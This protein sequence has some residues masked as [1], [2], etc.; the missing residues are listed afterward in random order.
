MTTTGTKAA[1]PANSNIVAFRNHF[2]NNITWPDK[3]AT[4]YFPPKYNLINPD[5][6]TWYSNC[7]HVE[8]AKR[9]K[10]DNPTTQTFEYLQIVIKSDVDTIQNP[11]G[12]PNVF[13]LWKRLMS[14]VIG[15]ENWV[16][17]GTYYHDTEY[18][19]GRG[20]SGIMHNMGMLYDTVG[21]V[22]TTGNKYRLKTFDNVNLPDAG[23]GGVFYHDFVFAEGFITG[24]GI[25]VGTAMT[26]TSGSETDANHKHRGNGAYF[27]PM[28]SQGIRS[29]EL[30]EEKLYLFWP[31]ELKDWAGNV[32]QSTHYQFHIDV[33]LDPTNV[34][35]VDTNSIMLNMRY[36]LR[37]GS[38]PTGKAGPIAT[39]AYQK[40]NGSVMTAF[41]VFDVFCTSKGTITYRS[42]V[43]DGAE[44]NADGNS[45]VTR[46]LEVP[47]D[48]Y[49]FD[50]SSDSLSSLTFP[51]NSNGIST[52]IECSIFGCQTLSGDVILSLWVPNE[53]NINSSYIYNMYYTIEGGLLVSQRRPR[54]RLANNPF[55]TSLQD[56]VV[57]TSTRAS[58]AVRMAIPFKS[59][60]MSASSCVIPYEAGTLSLMMI[61]LGREKSAKKI[62]LRQLFVDEDQSLLRP[63]SSEPLRNMVTSDQTFDL[64]SMFLETPHRICIGVQKLKAIV[65]GNVNAVTDTGLENL[66]QDHLVSIILTRTKSDNVKNEDSIL[67]LIM[68]TGVSNRGVSFSTREEDE[69]GVDLSITDD[70]V[71]QAIIPY[72]TNGGDQGYSFKDGGLVAIKGATIEVSAIDKNCVSNETGFA[73]AYVQI[74]NTDWDR[75]GGNNVI[76]RRLPPSPYHQP[77]YVPT[78]KDGAVIGLVGDS[79]NNLPAFGKRIVPLQWTISN[80]FQ[81]SVSPALREDT[82]HSA[83]SVLFYARDPLCTQVRVKV[84]TT[85]VQTLIVFEGIRSSQQTLA[86]VE[87]YD[88][89]GFEKLNQLQTYTSKSVLLYMTVDNNDKTETEPFCAFLDHMNTTYLSGLYVGLPA[90]GITQLRL[91]QPEVRAS[92]DPQFPRDSIMYPASLDW[93]ALNKVNDRVAHLTFSDTEAP[94]ITFNRPFTMMC[95]IGGQLFYS[96]S[97]TGAR[98]WTYNND[99]DDWARL[100]L[101]IDKDFQTPTITLNTH[102]FQTE[103]TIPPQLINSQ[104]STRVTALLTMKVPTLWEP[105]TRQIVYFDFPTNIKGS[106]SLTDPASLLSSLVI[107][108]Q[109]GYSVSMITIDEINIQDTAQQVVTVNFIL[110]VTFDGVPIEYGTNLEVTITQINR[111]NRDD[112]VK[113]TYSTAIADGEVSIPYTFN[114]SEYNWT[115]YA[116]SVS[117]ASTRFELNH[118][119]KSTITVTRSPGDQSVATTLLP[120][121]DRW[122]N[123]AV[124]ATETRTIKFLP[125]KSGTKVTGLAYVHNAAA[126]RDMAYSFSVSTTDTTFVDGLNGTNIPQ[127]L[128]ACMTPS[129][130]DQ[131]I[132]SVDFVKC[133][134]TRSAMSSYFYVDV[135]IRGI[136]SDSTE[137]I[138]GRARFTI[139]GSNLQDG[140]GDQRFHGIIKV[141]ELTDTGPSESN[142]I[143]EFTRYQVNLWYGKDNV[144][145]QAFVGFG[146]SYNSARTAVNGE[147]KVSAINTVDSYLCIGGYDL[148]RT[149]M[150]YGE[151]ILAN[152]N[153]DINY[154]QTLA[155]IPGLNHKMC[156]DMFGLISVGKLQQDDAVDRLPTAIQLARYMTHHDVA[157]SV[158]DMSTLG[159]VS[160]LAPIKYMGMYETFI[161]PNSFTLSQVIADQVVL[162]A[163]FQEG[164]KVTQA[165]SQR[166]AVVIASDIVDTVDAAFASPVW[167]SPSHSLLLINGI[168]AVDNNQMKDSTG[169]PL[170]TVRSTKYDI[171]NVEG[172]HQNPH[173]LSFGDSFDH[174]ARDVLCTNIRLFNRPLNLIDLSVTIN[175]LERNWMD[176]VFFY[177]AY[178]LLNS[179][180]QSKWFDYTDPDN[181]DRAMTILSLLSIVNR[182]PNHPSNTEMNYGYNNSLRPMIQQ[183]G[184]SGTFA[185][186]PIFT[187]SINNQGVIMTGRLVSSNNHISGQRYTTLD[188]VIVGQATVKFI[189]QKLGEPT[190]I[191]Y[192]EPCP[193]PGEN[194]TN[195]ITAYTVSPV[196]IA[197]TI[198][199]KL[200]QFTTGKTE[201]SWFTDSY[202][203][204]VNGSGGGAHSASAGLGVSQKFVAAHIMGVYSA[205]YSSAQRELYKNQSN[206]NVVSV[207]DEFTCITHG[208]KEL[209]DPRDET[210]DRP[211][212]NM[213]YMPTNTGVVYVE[214][215]VMDENIMIFNGQVV[216]RTQTRNEGIPPIRLTVPFPINPKYIFAG[217]LDGTIGYTAGDLNTPFIPHEIRAFFTTGDYFAGNKHSYSNADRGSTLT[218]LVPAERKLGDETYEYVNVPEDPFITFTRKEVNRGSKA[219]KIVDFDN[220]EA[221]K[222][223]AFPVDDSF[224]WAS[225]KQSASIAV[226]VSQ[227]R[228]GQTSSS[229]SYTVVHRDHYETDVYNF[230]KGMSGMLHMWVVQFESTVTYSG[231]DVQETS[232]VNDTT[233]T[234][235]VSLTNMI[236]QQNMDDP[237]Y[238]V[239]ATSGDFSNSNLWHVGSTV[240]AGPGTDIYKSS[241]RYE[242]S[243]LYYYGND[244]RMDL[245]ATWSEEGWIPGQVMDTGRVEPIPRPGQVKNYQFDSYFIASCEGNRSAFFDHIADPKWL[246]TDD[247]AM[248]LVN[249]R[250]AGEKPPDRVSHIVNYVDRTVVDFASAQPFAETHIDVLVACGNANPIDENT[251]SATL[252]DNTTL[253]SW[254]TVHSTITSPPKSIGKLLAL[255]LEHPK[256]VGATKKEMTSPLGT[257]IYPL[258]IVTNTP[259]ETTQPGQP[260]L[261]N[262]HQL[263]IKSRLVQLWNQAHTLLLDTVY[264]GQSQVY[265][266]FISSNTM[267]VNA[268]SIPDTSGSIA[269]SGDETWIRSQLTS[270][271]ADVTDIELSAMTRIFFYYYYN[272][273]IAELQKFQ[274]QDDTRD[275]PTTT[276]GLDPTGDTEPDS[277]IIDTDATTGTVLTIKSTATKPC[278]GRAWFGIIDDTAEWLPTEYTQWDDYGFADPV[279]P[280]VKRFSGTA[281][282]NANVNSFSLS[283]K[284]LEPIFH[285]IGLFNSNNA[286]LQSIRFHPLNTNTPENYKVL[287]EMRIDA[288]LIV[289]VTRHNSQEFTIDCHVEYQS[290]NMP[291]RYQRDVVIV[292]HTSAPG[293]I[294]AQGYVRH[295]QSVDG[296]P[297]IDAFY[298]LDLNAGDIHSCPIPVQKGLTMT[299]MPNVH[300]LVP[301]YYVARHVLLDGNGDLPPVETYTGEAE[302]YSHVATVM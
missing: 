88:I 32:I 108:I 183:N 235:T 193:V 291:T 125:P 126:T 15:D 241:P 132:G 97:S 204:S 195:T 192:A 201:K 139:L 225:L 17:F 285:R 104:Q 245:K 62:T 26:L 240:D 61:L 18:V 257:V 122:Q 47:L 6:E 159:I 82:N 232:L 248:Q 148:R 63:Y 299:D 168:P 282:A 144:P 149:G 40:N 128:F 45:D 110:G 91:Q 271:G 269:V 226:G 22:I 161:M 237:A 198:A 53:D 163:V 94:D 142:D 296:D 214:A 182:Y 277:L 145:K 154:S 39:D 281:F 289:F 298:P 124:T 170:P 41:G 66:Y 292:Y 29:N 206:Q 76:L 58:P 179:G 189:N 113:L 46:P 140:A 239:L 191:A 167:Q 246:Q 197:N 21:Q 272:L 279:V 216:A 221:Y 254:N 171:A 1:F 213:R 280:D 105:L 200:R 90:V 259:G 51:F 247:F 238:F 36:P 278:A 71:R 244:K 255:M 256:L 223:T 127:L 300:G 27:G 54:Y 266:D 228:S 155:A 284:A 9:D 135:Y 211:A 64:D 30:P 20:A 184:S 28:H 5:N 31:E 219:K 286:L 8:Q 25:P 129:T 138:T 77:T 80:N 233:V 99:D 87:T 121:M 143:P 52:L 141:V 69:P 258:A 72:A 169:S 107:P 147:R 264:I 174:T 251:P 111:L 185:T 101:R 103:W 81:R 118:V 188:P 160:A 86:V 181:S 24:F 67:G 276:P 231:D 156:I 287:R 215:Q 186:A 137:T 230:A 209:V 234:N 260:D 180:D 166:A 175:C 96:Q 229:R 116:F 73:S 13:H 196:I 222:K 172:I 153:S 109:N 136:V 34:A 85:S 37:Q 274:L 49:D 3:Y 102:G 7:V 261:G 98:L 253:V 293:I 210:K 203:T 68:S 242:Q 44:I 93:G 295:I 133:V 84:L 115:H 302:F 89:T 157:I 11:N 283:T 119:D 263:I 265:S 70:L 190:F 151:E 42:P 273:Q 78:A 212:M 14:E 146:A 301:D 243:I 177:S 290:G 262:D 202:T 50:R 178:S 194:L 19:N 250:S 218:K 297:D 33:R 130:N 123:I 23:P 57:D 100:G 83:C 65:P 288:N 74:V 294:L 35:D 165:T 75:D 176:P 131:D 12:N 114:P 2:F 205:D 199:Q 164:G 134:L 270:S 92:G 236:N 79:P 56:D 173:V 224:E 158:Q 252:P 268:T 267:F 208:L 207:Q 59:S 217:S 43:Q 162:D 10:I 249:R 4:I 106:G 227:S 60:K 187:T 120:L 275:V 95:D 48:F 117:V 152:G 16:R 55:F 220:L 38:Q 150:C 112:D